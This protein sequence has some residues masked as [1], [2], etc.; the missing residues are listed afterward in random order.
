[1]GN[2]SCDER[3]WTGNANLMFA[4]VDLRKAAFADL[5]PN[6]ELANGAIAC[7]RAPRGR[8]C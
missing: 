4:H 5:S 7:S 3:S 2:I 1:M 8:C 6:D